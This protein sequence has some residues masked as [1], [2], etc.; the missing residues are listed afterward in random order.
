M[1]DVLSDAAM[2]AVIV[3]FISPLLIAAVQQ[4]KWTTRSRAIVTFVWAVVVGS[5]TAFLSGDLN[6]RTLIST[7]LLILVV[8]VATYRGLW[9]PTGAAPAIERA[10]SPATSEVIQA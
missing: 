3:G 8:S 1:N 5:V 4:P 9:Q 10:T 2:W 7:V 6:G